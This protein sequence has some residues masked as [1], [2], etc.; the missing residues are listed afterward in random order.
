MRW[1]PFEEK[2]LV[3]VSVDDLERLIDEGVEEGL[4]LE[5]KS[6]WSAR[7]IARSVAAFA[8]TEGGT[9]IVGIKTDDRTPVE[10][11][12][13]EHAGD[14]GESIDNVV[15]ASI[16]P[17]PTF[18]FKEIANREGMP[19]LVVE[20]PRDESSRPFL[21][22]RTGQVMR[23]T[24]TG[25]EPAT[26]EYLDGLLMEGRA[27]ERWARDIAAIELKTPREA[28][29]L[30]T[31]PVVEGGLALGTSLFTQAFLD[32]LSTLVGRFPWVG[33]YG[34]DFVNHSVGADHLD[35]LTRDSFD[36][37]TAFHLR[38]HTT[39]IVE[40]VYTEKDVD[41]PVH[42]TRLVESS[43]PMHGELLVEA[44][45]FRARTVLALQET[46]RRSL[47]GGG[48]ETKRVAVTHPDF[49]LAD[50]LGAAE[51]AESLKRQIERSLG[52]WSPEPPASR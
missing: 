18:R 45:D 19:C 28:A 35:V 23:R 8:N 26:R 33:R 49:I 1:R 47:P 52:R 44:F 3:D 6:D 20:V 9:L 27:G 43:L 2:P 36:A 21:L 30:W 24:Q 37:G 38:A 42:L 12:G 17:L 41:G 48:E 32:R 11:V 16:A 39:G 25:T 14:I 31:I 7:Q 4:F 40:S 51:L 29:Y 34:G 13:I 46:W 50:E 15:R 22:S 5:Y 10:L